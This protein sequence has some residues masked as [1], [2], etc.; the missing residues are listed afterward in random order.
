[1]KKS[2]L[3][4]APICVMRDG[5]DIELEVHATFHGDEQPEIEFITLDGTDTRWTGTLTEEETDMA[6]DAIVSVWQDDAEGAYE[7][8]QHSRFDHAGDR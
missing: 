3:T 6:N 4:T 5:E 8:Y 2:T 1:M 7:D